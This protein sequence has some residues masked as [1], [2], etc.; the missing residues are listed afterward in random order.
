MGDSKNEVTRE[1]FIIQD[2]QHQIGVQASVI[3][4]LKYTCISLEQKISKLESKEDE[5]K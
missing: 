3:S 4:D 2:L 1:Q 5:Q